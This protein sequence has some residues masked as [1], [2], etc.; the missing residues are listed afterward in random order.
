[1]SNGWACGGWWNELSGCDAKDGSTDGW[2]VILLDVLSEFSSS[3]C[4]A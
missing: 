4:F 3:R 1:M 2:C